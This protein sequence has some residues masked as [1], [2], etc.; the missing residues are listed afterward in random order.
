MTS[1]Y[2]VL[3]LDATRLTQAFIQDWLD[4]ESHALE[5]NIYLSYY[6]AMPAIKELSKHEKPIFIAIYNTTVITSKLV[7]LAIVVDKPGCTDFP[8][9]HIACYE[10]IHSYLSGILLDRA[11]SEE[12]AK[13]FFSYLADSKRP[14]HGLRINHWCSDSIQ[15]MLMQNAAFECGIRWSKLHS[16]ERAYIEPKLSGEQSYLLSHTAAGG[17]DIDR[18]IRRLNELG[19]LKHRVLRGP[20]VTQN[21]IE[22]FIQLEDRDWTRQ[23]KTSLLATGHVSFFR[24]VCEP[25][26]SK[27]RIFVSEILIDEQ[28]I[29]SAFNFIAGDYGFAFKIG[30]DQRL[31][32]MSPG[33]INELW[34]MRDINTVCGDLKQIDSGA[35]AGSFI[36]KI[37]PSRRTISTGFFVTSIQ[38]RAALSAIGYAKS[39]RNNFKNLY[40]NSI[41]KPTI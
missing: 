7:G 25:L 1:T 16:F 21:T 22:K 31:S 28:P 36:E 5:Q 3:E 30:W 29:A 40:K 8:L 27:S 26:I 39:I 41:K 37:W 23:A 4:L 24:Q 19:N 20:D 34:F 11:S 10:S 33:I 18:R 13:A 32:K 35:S 17:K 6:F 15:G 38:G 14:W 12:A 2:K 9:R